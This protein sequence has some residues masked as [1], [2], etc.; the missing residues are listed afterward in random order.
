MKP[1]SLKLQIEVDKAPIEE[2]RD[3][4]KE[5]RDTAKAAGITKRQLRK[6]VKGVISRKGKR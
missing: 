1:S 5:I 4:V 2:V 6:I 3:I